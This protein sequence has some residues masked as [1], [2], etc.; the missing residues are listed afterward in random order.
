MENP[1]NPGGPTMYRYTVYTESEGTT[2]KKT[3]QQ[4]KDK[5]M[6]PMDLDFSFEEVDLGWQF[7]ASTNALADL[8][9][10]KKALPKRIESSASASGS[11]ASGSQ[12]PMPRHPLAIEDAKEKE[13]LLIKAEEAVRGKCGIVFEAKKI[14]K[15]RPATPLAKKRCLN[16]EELKVAVEGFTAQLESI[17][18]NGTMPNDT[19]PVSVATLKQLLKDSWAYSKDL[20]QACLMAQAL[21]PKKATQAKED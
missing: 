6:D 7:K 17:T 2:H 18:I 13:K 4:A 10:G 16:L 21:M 15:A 20:S 11:H 12:D 1:E 5:V 19:R 9:A 3:I 8:A 14:M